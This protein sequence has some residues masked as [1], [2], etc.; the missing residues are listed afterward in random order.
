MQQV[1]F[2]QGPDGV[3]RE[4]D[5]MGNDQDAEPGVFSLSGNIAACHGQDIDVQ[6]Q[7]GHLEDAE[8]KK[9]VRIHFSSLQHENPI[10]RQVSHRATVKYTIIEA[11]LQG[12]KAIGNQSGEI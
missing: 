12:Y 6:Q 4:I 7:K 9:D 8:C 1:V 11:N 3:H 5:H 10:F 2:L